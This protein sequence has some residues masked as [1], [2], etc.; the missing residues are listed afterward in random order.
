MSV[1]G[2]TETWGWR[3]RKGTGPR[4][5]RVIPQLTGAERRQDLARG[6]EPLVYGGPVRRGE[7]RESNLEPSPDGSLS[8]FPHKR[9]P[10]MGVTG[11]GQLLDKPAQPKTNKEA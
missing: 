10:G 5:R 8:P 4:L 2:G 9:I 7:D 1:A 3:R 11:S 6:C